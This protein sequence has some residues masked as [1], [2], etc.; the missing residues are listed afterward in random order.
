MANGLSQHQLITL[1]NKIIQQQRLTHCLKNGLFYQCTKNN[2]Y[3]TT[4]RNSYRNSSGRAMTVDIKPN[5]NC[6]DTLLEMDTT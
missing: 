4:I 5:K 3:A 6:F 1:K 2:Q